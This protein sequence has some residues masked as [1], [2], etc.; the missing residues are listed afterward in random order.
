MADDNYMFGTKPELSGNDDQRE[1][2]RLVARARAYVQLESPE[3]EAAGLTDREVL[4][5]QI[6]DLSARGISLVSPV[7]LVEGSI[8]QSDIEA[9]PDSGLFR[10][11]IEVMWCRETQAGYLVG[12]R[13]LESDGTDYLEWIETVARALTDT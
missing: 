5:C 10:L 4:E 3:P 7:S 1:E 9:G 8:L 13:V 2:Y 12:V 6:R 11:I